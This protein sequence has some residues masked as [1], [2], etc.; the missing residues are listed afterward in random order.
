M[1]IARVDNGIVK[2]VPFDAA[3][4]GCQQALVHGYGQERRQ[5]EVNHEIGVYHNNR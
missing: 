3:E 5:T 2:L 1:A 4:D